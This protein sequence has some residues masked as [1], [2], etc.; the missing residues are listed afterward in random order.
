MT[1]YM[2]TKVSVLQANAKLVQKG[3]YWTYGATDSLF[4]TSGDVSSRFQ[5]QSGQSYSHLVEVYVTELT[6]QVLI[7][8]YLILLLL[9]HHLTFRF[10][11]NQ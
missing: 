2:E 5:G 4:W 7:G 11:S 9:V 10:S 1:I 6:W 3:E 8:V